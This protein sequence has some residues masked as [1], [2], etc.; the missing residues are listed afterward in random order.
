MNLTIGTR[1]VDGVV[2]LDL[3]GKIILGEECSFLREHVKQLLANHQNRILLNLA[4]VSFIDSTG[5]GT[6]VSIFSSVKRQG[7]HLKLCQIS[8]RF[9]QTLQITRLFTVFEFYDGEDEA[10]ASF[11]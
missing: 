1:N 11:R 3:A 8:R 2:I 9:E 7:G 4:E 5:V 10:L 6:L